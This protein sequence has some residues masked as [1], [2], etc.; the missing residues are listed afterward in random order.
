MKRQAKPIELRL[1]LGAGA[2]FL[3]FAGSILLKNQKRSSP[4]ES[5]LPMFIESLKQRNYP[6]SQ[7]TIEKT[8]PPG[9]NYQRYLVFYHSDNL[10]IYGYLTVPASVKPP[11]GFPAILLLHGYVN[12]QNYSPLE[13]YAASQDGLARAGFVTFKPDF[14]GHGQS[15]GQALS[16]P[17]A[18]S[19]LIDALN[20]LSAL[21]IHPAVDPERI[22]LWGHS[23]GGA[24]ALRVLVISKDIKAAVI[25]AGVVGTYQDL[26][27]TYRPRVPWLPLV[28]DTVFLQ[29]HGLPSTNPL[30]WNKLDIYPYLKE[31]T[32]PV[33]LH[34]GLA[35]EE[36]P[37]EFSIHL[38]N[39]LESLGKP[40]E[41][42]SYPGANHNF[43]GPA[44]NLALRRS[45]DF[46]KKHL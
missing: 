17:F 19:Y 32:T 13:D 34:H 7:I 18:E 38:K 46:F 43:T 25:W 29:Q 33:Q 44:F 22:G 41:F 16:S 3:L 15:E 5:Q 14:R 1:I 42:Y 6:A 12:P 2:V 31:I 23:N 45:V 8:L 27:E 11:K 35:D 28:N 4:L 24:I 9:S 36:V 26:L 21:K 39:E 37:P 20:A 10:K 30:F 40:V